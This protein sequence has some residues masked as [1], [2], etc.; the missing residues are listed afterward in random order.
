MSIGIVLRCATSASALHYLHLY[1][2]GSRI[3][4]PIALSLS[5]ALGIILSSSTVQ[6]VGTGGFGLA[7][8][9]GQMRILNARVRVEEKALREEFGH[10]YDRYSRKTWKFLPGW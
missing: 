1:R 6:A 2:L 7:L 5:S 9:A 4:R 3:A 8:L 10:E